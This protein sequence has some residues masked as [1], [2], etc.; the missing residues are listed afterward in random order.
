[1]EKV[2]VSFCWMKKN[3]SAGKK[4]P[5]YASELASG[6]D[7]AAAL[8]D[9]LTLEP[10]ERALVP[11]GFGLAIPAGFE[12]QVR[13][14]SGLAVKHGLTVINAPGTIDADYRGEIKVALVNLGQEPFII[15]PGDR[16]AQLILAPVCQARLEVVETLDATSRGSGGFGHTGV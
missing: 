5:E 4:L 9:P 13:P 7:V 12:V 14:R 1:M 16:I 8:D 11:T 10:G 6:M 15:H 3:I 2:V